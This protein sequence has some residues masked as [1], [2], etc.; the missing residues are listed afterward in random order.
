MK[1]NKIVWCDR[2][3]F[4]ADIG[5]CPTKKAWNKFCKGIK[6]D[7][8][9]P[10]DA[11]YFTCFVDSNGSHSL[12]VTINHQKYDESKESTLVHESV[13]VYQEILKIMG[14]EEN[15]GPEIEAYMIQFIFENLYRAYLKTRVNGDKK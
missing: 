7:R 2:S 13:H 14:Q 5:F 4:P 15:P 9:Y 12:V 6:I 11:G 10:T 8:K 3:F 1:K